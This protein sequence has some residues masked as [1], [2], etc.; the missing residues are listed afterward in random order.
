MDYR[1]GSQRVGRKPSVK[2]PPSLLPYQVSRRD[3]SPIEHGY[4]FSPGGVSP[5]S[6]NPGFYSV[7]NIRRMMKPSFAGD[8]VS[9]SN[10]YWSAPIPLTEQD[11]ELAIADAINKRYTP[12][13]T[14]MPE[15]RNI[16][17]RLHDYR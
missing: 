11:P 4:V 14:A 8:D 12:D 13:F 9:T 16:T 1:G 15:G 7:G 2:I 17:Q 3:E 6:A 10:P 5:P